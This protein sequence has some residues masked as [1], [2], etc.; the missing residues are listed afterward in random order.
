MP[1]STSSSLNSALEAREVRKSAEAFSSSLAKP[2][3]TSGDAV[4]CVFA[5]DG[6][7]TAGDVYSSRELFRRMWPKLVRAAALEALAAEV[8]MT[9]RD[10]PTLESVTAFLGAA[11]SKVRTERKVNQRMRVL[12]KGTDDVVV[13]ETWDRRQEGSW[14]HRTYIAR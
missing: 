3:V 4:G 14:I 13:F 7:L 8:S 5:I 6:K 9:P 10:R 12:Q 1:L 11:D 2:V